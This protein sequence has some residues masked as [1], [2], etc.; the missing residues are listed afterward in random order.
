MLELLTHSVIQPVLILLVVMLLEKL[1]VWPAQAHPLTMLRSMAETMGEKVHKSKN[2]SPT[3]QRISGTLAIV[4]LSLPVVFIISAILFF[5]EY[6]FFFEGLLLLIALRFQPVMS[7]SKKLQ[8]ALDKRKK[9]LARNIL[10]KWT[11]RETE[12]LSE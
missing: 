10:S 1:I 12:A 7:D 4:V 8:N 5:A 3:Q 2:N 6:A 11:L 9:A